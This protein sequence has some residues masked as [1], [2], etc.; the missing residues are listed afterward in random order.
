MITML[1][2][3]RQTGLTPV[4][5]LLLILVILFL[6]RFAISVMPAYLE[7]FSVTSSLK[8]LREEA[9]KGFDKSRL[10]EILNRRLSINDVQHVTAEDIVIEVQGKKTVVRIDYQVRSTFIGNIDAVVSFSDS[11]EVIH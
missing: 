10:L 9:S 6:A 4:G 11:V 7:N 8:S 2:V 3:I 5:V 1:P